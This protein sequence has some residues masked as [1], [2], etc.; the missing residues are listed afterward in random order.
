VSHFELIVAGGGAG[1][2]VTAAGAAVV[3]APVALVARAPLSG[4]CLWN[5]CVPSKA[6][7]ACAKTAG[8]ARRA[9]QFGVIADPVVDS[10]AV[11][12]R[13][14]GAAATI[15]PHDRPGLGKLV[16]RANGE[17]LGGHILEAGA[18]QWFGE[19]SLALKMKLGVRALTGL[20]HPRSTVSEA[21]RQMAEEHQEARF[22][23]AVRT[24]ARWIVRRSFA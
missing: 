18:A 24:L 9:R 10:A 6:L 1:G 5:G 15:A 22:T 11:M 23:G 13:V 4:E 2:L 16:T 12:R 3:A 14:H 19:V 8:H 17:L 21:I 20:V 7:L